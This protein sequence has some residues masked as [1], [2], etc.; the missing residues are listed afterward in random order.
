MKCKYFCDS[1]WLP[2]KAV[3]NISCLFIL[4]ERDIGIWE[5]YKNMIQKY[6]M[7]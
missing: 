1:Q 5:A 2:K 4:K 7:I 3:K 6:D